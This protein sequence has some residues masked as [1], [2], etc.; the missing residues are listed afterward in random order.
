MTKNMLIFN[1]IKTNKEP[2][3][4]NLF[5]LSELYVIVGVLLTSGKHVHNHI[6]SPR[7][8]VCANHTD[9][10]PSIS[11]KMPVTSQ[12]SESSCISV[13][14]VSIGPVFLYISD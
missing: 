11:F 6:I 4:I 13:L 7:V 1:I 9:L 12:E 3:L 8:E 10:T 5:L 14:E 2:N